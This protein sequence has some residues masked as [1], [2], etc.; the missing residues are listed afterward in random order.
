VDHHARHGKRC[1][2]PRGQRASQTLSVAP[3]KERAMRHVGA[4]IE[5]T[6]LIVVVVVLL[7]VVVRAVITFL[8]S[9]D[10]VAFGFWLL[11]LFISMHINY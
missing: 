6:R 7:F 5:L 10:N 11:I 1:C 4:K 3:L 2:G 8:S 9:F